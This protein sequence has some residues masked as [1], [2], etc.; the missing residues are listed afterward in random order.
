M[1]SGRA[2]LDLAPPAVG[3]VDL[4]PG[5]APPAYVRALAA[6]AGAPVDDCR[7]ALAAPADYPSRKAILFLFRGD[8]PRPSFVVKLTRD[9][10]FNDRLEN[11]RRALDALAA[12]G[13]GDPDTVPRATFFGRHAG[14]AVLGETAVAGVPFRQVTTARADCPLARRAADWLVDLAARTADP[15]AAAPADVAG[16]LQQLL[17][18]FVALYR[19][20]AA[21]RALLE[22]QVDAIARSAAPFPVVLQHGD[23]GT[24]NLLIGE[25]GRPAFLDWEAAETHGM[26]LWD[27]FYF[28]RS[29]AVTVARR[30]GTRSALDAFA[31]HYLD[32]GPLGRWLGGV[33]E[34]YCAQIGLD[35]A[36]V[37]PLFLT[38]WMHRA[39]KEATSLPPEHLQ[40]GRYVALL[41]LSL[42]RGAEAPGLRRLYGAAS[43]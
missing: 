4:P 36:L 19:P 34:A 33:V 2:L 17:E 26:P 40:S 21:E 3:A 16:A 6:A 39:L 15:D 13:I 37:G 38:C 8:A 35:R 32:D 18:R 5:G 25:G 23:P 1:R 27:L 10:A 41:R 24:W 42:G 14:L 9:P 22:A 20:D 31:E 7:T 28:A 43:A 29:V 11:E 12:K 30:A